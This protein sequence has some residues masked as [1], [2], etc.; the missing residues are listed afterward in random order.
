MPSQALQL[1]ASK[2]YDYAYNGAWVF[3]SEDN[4]HAWHSLAVA[5]SCRGLASTTAR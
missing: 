2:G 3:A 5:T 1:M 4:P